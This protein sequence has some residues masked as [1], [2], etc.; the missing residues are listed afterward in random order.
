MLNEKESQISKLQNEN[1]QNVQ[2]LNDLH[3]INE[4]QQNELNIA[5]KKVEEIMCQN[6]NNDN[7]DS[8]GKELI[9]SKRRTPNSA[10]NSMDFSN[11]IHV[12]LKD[13]NVSLHND[14][15]KLQNE[16]E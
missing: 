16:N 1:E 11:E 12:Q 7:G 6:E 3:K 2:K 14:L 9:D 13:E 4:K 15:N 10:T 5:M 8:N